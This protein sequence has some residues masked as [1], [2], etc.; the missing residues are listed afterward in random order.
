MDDNKVIKIAFKPSRVNPTTL[1]VQH[2][3]PQCGN[4][5]WLYKTR[6]GTGKLQGDQIKLKCTE[7]GLY[8][9]TNKNDIIVALV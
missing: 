8:F 6:T 7:C 4:E 3:C 1:D 2:N 9:I 5:F